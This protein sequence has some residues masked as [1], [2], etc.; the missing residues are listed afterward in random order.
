MNPEPGLSE[1]RSDRPGL[2]E[3]LHHLVQVVV[4]GIGRIGDV[5]ALGREG[6]LAVGRFLRG[7]E[8]AVFAAE[9]VDLLT[10]ASWIWN[11]IG[12]PS[13]PEA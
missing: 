6:S 4:A 13:G 1:C 5:E 3:G 10:T 8:G 2:Q 11:S 9:P 7:E 12:F